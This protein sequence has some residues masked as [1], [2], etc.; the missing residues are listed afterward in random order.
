MKNVSTL[1]AGITFLLALITTASA[2][3][4]SI[5]ATAIADS[6]NDNDNDYGS[7]T[8]SGNANIMMNEV[9]T[10]FSTRQSFLEFPRWAARLFS[11]HTLLLLLR[12]SPRRVELTT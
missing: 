7:S 1:Y 12:V 9:G 11:T 10:S 5:G 6:A 2:T 3:D 8:L 4:P